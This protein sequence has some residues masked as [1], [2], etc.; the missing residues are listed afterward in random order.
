MTSLDETKIRS[1]LT[2]RIGKGMRLGLETCDELLYRLGRPENNFPCIHV[3]GSNGKGTLCA[4]LS[5]IGARNGELI[6]V[7]TSPHLISIE[8]RT[9]IDGKPIKSDIYD[10]YLRQIKL[11]SEKNPEIFPTYFEITFL[12]SIL[13]FSEARVDR[14]VI[15]T[16]LG[17][18]LDASRLCNADLCAIT[19]ISKEHTEILGNSLEEIAREKLGI[20]RE[21]VPLFCIYNENKK[22]RDIFKE[23]AGSD[24]RFF[25]SKKS[26]SF[27]ISSEYASLISKSLGW[28]PYF[29]ELNW[30][31]RTET[32]FPW[33][34]QVKSKISAAHNS[35]SFQNDISQLNN[36]K[37]IL[38]IGMS[39]KPDLQTHLSAFRG[40]KSFEYVILTEVSGG[41]NPTVPVGELEKEIS[42]FLDN[43]VNI[44]KIIN[45]IE[46][47]DFATKLA[48]IEGYEIFITGSIY[49]IGELLDEYID[50]NSLDFD[51]IMTIHPPR[52]T[53]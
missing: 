29:S 34:S 5:S 11:A 21:G 37:K 38:L 20:Y 2:N 14:A 1:W 19:T 24:L 13:A 8:E 32:N 6:G 10:K 26:N 16:G 35:E 46:A 33:C 44:N 28:K 3:A 47:M 39:S 25:K 42:K 43:H 31:G 52:E 50:R 17:G 18:R 9:R 53:E 12:V 51:D 30:F 49:L 23:V 15:E 4:N 36:N 45:P 48:L 41:R 27:E 7:F 22:V 40:H